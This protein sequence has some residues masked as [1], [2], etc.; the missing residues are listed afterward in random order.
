MKSFLVSSAL[1]AI[2]VVTAGCG[3]SVVVEKS[4]YDNVELP[5]G[6]NRKILVEVAPEYPA[7]LRKARKE[8]VVVVGFAVKPDGTVENVRVKF[9]TYPEL[10]PLAVNAVQ[11]WIFAP[12]PDG[13][14]RN[15]VLEV[16]ITFSVRDQGN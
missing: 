10:A 3:S 6:R 2:L 4:R 1:I 16:P 11:Q 8:G 7:S 14:K 9:A 12:S 15:M 13:D 5:S